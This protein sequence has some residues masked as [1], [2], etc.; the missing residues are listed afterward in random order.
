MKSS[1]RAMMTRRNSNNFFR[2]IFTTAVVCGIGIG[3]YLLVHRGLGNGTAATINTDPNK[4]HTL[5]YEDPST[6]G[7]RYLG[8]RSQISSIVESYKNEFQTASDSHM[9]KLVKEKSKRYFITAITKNI[10]PYW[11]GTKFGRKQRTETPQQGHIGS[12]EFVLGVLFD[13]GL[14]FDYDHWTKQKQFS[15]MNSLVPTTKLR[16]TFRNSNL[17]QL[18]SY[19]R[20][21]GRGLYLVYTSDVNFGFLNY[22]EDT[23]EFT[24]A[25][26]GSCVVTEKLDS[27]PAFAGKKS[28]YVVKLSD[29]GRIISSWVQDKKIRIRN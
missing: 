27:S 9:R 1:K 12:T 10:L 18:I 7:Q 17:S 21:S 2:T 13:L 26:R 24:Y 20:T 25:K 19:L 4:V 15:I 8:T 14:N 28:F 23:F 5:N 29:E 3:A 16:K 6:L 22:A 11:N